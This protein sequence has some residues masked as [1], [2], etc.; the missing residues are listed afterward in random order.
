MKFLNYIKTSAPRVGR[1]LLSALTLEK[2]ICRL[3]AS[4]C[5]FI[6]IGLKGKDIEYSKLEFAQ[7]T[8]ISTFV[9]TILAFFLLYTVVAAILKKYYTDSVF[10]MLGATFCSVKWIYNYNDSKYKL[11]VTLAIIAVYC[12]FLLYFVHRNEELISKISFGKG[13][14]VGCAVLFGVLSATVIAAITCLRYKNFISPNYDFGIFCNMFHY[15]RETGLPLTTCERDGLLSHFAVHISPIF[16]LLLPVYFV[17]PSPLTLQIGQAVVIASGVIPVV[18]IARQLGL[19]KKASTVAGFIYCLY[20]ALNTGCF[21]DIHENCF[22]APIL[23]WMF[24]FFEKKK[25]IPMYIFALLVLMVKEDAAIYVCIFALFIILSRKKYLH[26][27]ILA[28]ASIAYFL[29]A[30]KILNSFGDGAMV[31]RYS[32]LIFDPEDGVFGIIKTGLFNPGFFLTQLFTTKTATF[33]KFIYFIQML[34]PLGFLPFCSKKPSHWLL[35]SPMLMNLLTYYVY[36]YDITFQYNFGHSAFL[37]YAMLVNLPDLKMPT[38][39]TLL[40]IGAAACC[41]LYISTVLPKLDS[42]AE[43]YK[44][45]K[46]TYAQIEEILDTVPK[47]A[48]VNAVSKFV[49]HM[50][51]REIIYQTEYHGNKPDVDYVVLDLRNMDSKSQ[52]TKLA[53]LKAGYTVWAKHDGLVLILEK[54]ENTTESPQ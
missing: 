31:N 40:S 22:L 29:I 6:A 20:P 39:R 28:G 13:A 8:K 43:N 46:E 23:L 4:W 51:D 42:Y 17:F 9:L 49:A 25:Y 33:D 32:N 2:V 14:F 47:D 10:L 52:A 12:L 26:G 7:D 50:A 11:L 38:R 24:Y 3:I 15:M 35:L 41:F 27:A 30:V 45:N 5:T 37:I 44:K 16:Y 36:Q 1:S 48:S 53:Y 18:L 54:G 21:Y 19:S 34:L